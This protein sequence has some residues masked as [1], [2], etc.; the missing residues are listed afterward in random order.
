MPRAGPSHAGKRCAIPADLWPAWPWWKPE[1]RGTRALRRVAALGP[2]P[3]R[4]VP[5]RTGTALPRP[6]R[7]PPLASRAQPSFVRS[8]LRE[9][10]PGRPLD[11]VVSN[12]V[13]H[14]L[15]DHALVLEQLA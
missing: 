2:R 10:R 14:W 9:W 4:A 1:R 7:A 13:L 6:A 5:S 12:A 3:V 8:D 11:L 15:P